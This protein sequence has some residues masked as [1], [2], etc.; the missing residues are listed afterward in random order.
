MIDVRRDVVSVT[1][2]KQVPWDHSALTGEFYFDLKA[3]PQDNAALRDEVD[4]LKKQ[5]ADK[6]ARAP[7][8]RPRRLSFFCAS[9]SRR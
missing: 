9:A 6:T 8:R 1:E 4:N 7:A 5:L 3:K 2:G